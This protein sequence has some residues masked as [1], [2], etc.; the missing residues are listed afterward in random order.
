MIKVLFIIDGL[1]GGGKER[2]L[3]E[4]VKVLSKTSSLKTGII[5]FNK[6]TYYSE[7]IKKLVPFFVELKKRPTRLE[8]FFTIWKQITTFKPDVIHTWDSLSS[9]Y[10]YLPMKYFK[11]KFIDGS[12][13]DAGIEKGWRLFLKKYFLKRAD[14]VIANS[15]AGLQ[16]YDVVGEVIYNAIDISRFYTR[17][18]TDEVNSIMVANFT[19]YKDHQTFIDASIELAKMD[20]TDNIFLAGDGP[21]KQ[22][23]ID[24]L[25]K[26]HPEIFHRFHFLGLTGNVEKY[27]SKCRF[28]VLCS[29]S[30]YS[31]GVSNSILEYMAAGLVAIATDVGGMGEAINNRENGFLIEEKKPD[32]IVNIISMLIKD[33]NLSKNIIKE[34]RRTIETKFS[35]TGNI[36]KL[37]GIYEKLCITG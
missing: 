12:I 26:N 23:H 25:K 30:T 22:A 3:Y 13:R 14:L 33:R 1:G 29:T 21:Y 31:E 5:T 36:N 8:P 9:M 28:G 11:V 16:S 10:V 37:K 17:E 2:Q 32:H 15:K 34:A 20:L 27:L 4:I 6:N 19:D 24:S 35:Y 7:R 18:K